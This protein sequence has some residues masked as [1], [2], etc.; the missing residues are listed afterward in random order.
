MNIIEA[1][2]SRHS[3]R[4]FRP[5]PVAKETLLKIATAA[6]RSPSWANSQPWEVIIAAGEP[7]ERLRQAF[8]ARYDRGDPNQPDVPRPPFFPPTLQA[9]MAETTA[10][11]LAAEGTH[12]DDPQ[13]RRR[14]YAFFGA[15]AVLYLGM[16]RG[17]NQWSLFDLGMFCQSVMLAAQGVGVGSI[18][19][20]ML[21]AYPDLIRQELAVPQDLLLVLG[22]ALGYPVQEH[23]S[24]LFRSDRRPVE[25][26]V[27]FEGV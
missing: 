16:D 23:P 12:R 26:A 15:P 21:V 5:E 10:R 19:A 14:N 17:A 27:R 9:R 4:A 20:I 7:L 13:A 2:N 25:E 6:N 1:L 18:P 24:N 8:L 22:I 11:R 3:V